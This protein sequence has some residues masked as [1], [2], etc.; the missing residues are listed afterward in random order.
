MTFDEWYE[1]NVKYMH[2]ADFNPWLSEAWDAAVLA[3]REACAKVC[4]EK[5]KA[6]M[7]DDYRDACQDI[8]AAIQSRSKE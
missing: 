3:E 5:F 8:R 6:C 2:I 4:E 1:A 7:F